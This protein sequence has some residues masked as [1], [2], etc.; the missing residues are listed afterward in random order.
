MTH[1]RVYKGRPW[2]ARLLVI[3]LGMLCLAVLIQI[4]LYPLLD[5][6]FSAAI[7]GFAFF[8]GTALPAAWLAWLLS[9]WRGTSVAVEGGV[10]KITE[11]YGREWRIVPSLPISVTKNGIVRLGNRSVT[12]AL[13]YPTWNLQVD[14]H[15]I[16]LRLDMHGDPDAEAERLESALLSMISGD[17]GSG[18]ATL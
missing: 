4:C 8:V 1:A 5:H 12:Y 17:V 15:S 6:D 9:R 2:E 14:G 13:P 3:M 10:V 18:G 7:V 16:F 11:W